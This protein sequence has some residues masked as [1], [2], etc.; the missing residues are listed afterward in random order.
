MT[1]DTLTP[2][3]AYQEYLK[4]DHW[5]ALR[6]A[7]L[8]EAFHICQKC[9]R[10]HNLQVHHLIYRHPWTSA[11]LSDLKVLC[12]NCH[13]RAHGLYVHDHRPKK[14]IRQSKTIQKRNRQRH[15]RKV[16]KLS[17][18]ARNTYSKYTHALFGRVI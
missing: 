15:D 13:R 18:S 14:R 3:Q 12:E 10:D 11:V 8:E 17:R 5:K 16:R 7:K 9:Y 6:A 1:T 2:K 4:S